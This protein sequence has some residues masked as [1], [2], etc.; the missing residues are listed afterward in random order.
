MEMP[1]NLKQYE[2]TDKRRRTKKRTKQRKEDEGRF[3]TVEIL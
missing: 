3:R 1:P 2:E